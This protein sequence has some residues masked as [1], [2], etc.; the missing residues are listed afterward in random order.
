MHLWNHRPNKKQDI[1]GWGD[2]I[3][4]KHGIRLRVDHGRQRNFFADDRRS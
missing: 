2:E 1:G 3:S 4:E